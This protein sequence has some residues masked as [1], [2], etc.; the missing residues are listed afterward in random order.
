MHLLFCLQ[1]ATLVLKL[2]RVKRSSASP[3]AVTRPWGLSLH[4][5]AANLACLQSLPL[6]RRTMR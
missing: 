4:L 1:V 5:L 3:Q 6:A 2:C